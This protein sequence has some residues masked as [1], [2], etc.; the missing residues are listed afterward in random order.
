MYLAWVTILS[1]EATD[2]ASAA[3]ASCQ[4]AAPTCPGAWHEAQLDS[5]MG[6]TTVLND[7][8]VPVW[9]AEAGAAIWSGMVNFDGSSATSLKV[10]PTES[11]VLTK[12]AR[13]MGPMP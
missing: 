9:G 3:V 1:P 5:R 12:P 7:G 2:E 13:L 6:A 4:W 11:P 8:P 10:S